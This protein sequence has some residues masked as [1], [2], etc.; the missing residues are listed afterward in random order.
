MSTNQAW[1]DFELTFPHYQM[2]KWMI[3]NRNISVYMG[4][5]YLGLLFIGRKVMQ[6][7]EPFSLRPLLTMWNLFMAAFSILVTVRVVPYFL[8]RIVTMPFVDQVCIFE[9]EDIPTLAAWHDIFV[10]TKP[11][12]FVDTVFI[13]LRKQHL[14]F[15]HYYHHITVVV[16]CWFSLGVDPLPP[17]V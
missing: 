16:L 7:R 12:E 8:K 1:F 3:E 17:T 15:L 9:Y 11:M 5:T 10:I 6:N 13:V 14:H 4:L 2:K